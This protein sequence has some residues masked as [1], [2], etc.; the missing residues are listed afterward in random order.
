MSSDQIN[1]N[2]SSSKKPDLKVFSLGRFEVEIAGVKIPPKEWGRDKTIQ[3]FQ[4]LICTRQRRALH[5]EQIVDGLWPDANVDSGDRDFKVALHGINK[6]LEPNRQTRAEPKFVI[7]QGLT[8]QLNMSHIWLDV[9]EIE[10]LV[11]IGNNAIN[12]KEAVEA[13]K[14]AVKLYEGPFL[15]NRFYEDWSSAERERI[16]VIILSAIINLAQR[17][18][19]K[20]PME[21]I[22]LCEKA[23]AIDKTWEDAYRI[24]MEAFIK[25]GNR[26][27]AIK[28]FALCEKVLDEEFGIS[29]LPRTKKL[30]QEI[31]AI[32]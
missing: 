22:R 8:Y 7:R 3:L 2:I 24:Q 12:P 6:T 26:P 13:L 14:K 5:K 1:I 17:L 27:Q 9:D 15:P 28:T 30:L 10:T 25:N 18:I 32:V 20:N 16:Q 19:S 31:E 11:E 4:Y 23:L 29:P 21:T